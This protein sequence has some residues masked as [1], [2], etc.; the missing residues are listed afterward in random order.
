MNRSIP[1]P[2]INQGGFGGTRYGEST[3]QIQS[4]GRDHTPINEIAYQ[5]RLEEED[6]IMTK[7]DAKPEV[8]FIGQIL[9]GTNFNSTDGLFCEMLIQIGENWEMLSPNKL[10]QTQ[11]CYADVDEIFVW[12][13]PFDIFF[14]A[15]DLSGW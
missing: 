14:S 2:P 3:G 4:S 6:K 13:H 7:G 1:L 5:K 12:G 15:G 8:H 9:G 11:T 10:Y